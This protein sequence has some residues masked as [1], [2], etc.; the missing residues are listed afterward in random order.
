MGY[1]TYHE[2]E[3]DDGREELHAKGIGVLS[4]YGSEVFED[5][6]KWYEMEDDMETYSRR[7]PDV[8]FTITQNGEEFDDFG[9]SYFRAGASVYVA[10]TVTYRELTPEENTKL[11]IPN[12]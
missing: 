11:G 2:L 4:E 7:Y 12:V 10:G 8:L 5:C 3:V 1:Q 6:I 9:K